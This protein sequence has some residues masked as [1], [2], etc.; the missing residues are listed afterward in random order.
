MDM[1]RRIFILVLISVMCSIYAAS[2]TVVV[3]P[4]NSQNPPKISEPTPG[5]ANMD[6]MTE[7]VGGVDMSLVP[8]SSKKYGFYCVR[9]KNENEYKVTVTYQFRY[10]HDEK[11][12]FSGTMVLAPG[13]MKKTELNYYFP[14]DLS[15]T[16]R[17][18]KSAK[19]LYKR[20]SYDYNNRL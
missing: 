15:C 17:P 20:D 11:S 5:A 3:I 4:G 19:D 13:E 14:K 8:S 10:G 12:V 1:T 18:L 16:V 6:L 7:D 2:Q 9:L